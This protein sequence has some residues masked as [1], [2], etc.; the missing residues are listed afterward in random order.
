MGSDASAALLPRAHHELSKV[1]LSCPFSVLVW[2][3]DAGSVEEG[4]RQQP[5]HQGP[6]C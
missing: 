1:V 3:A 4:P 5:A 2:A 6:H